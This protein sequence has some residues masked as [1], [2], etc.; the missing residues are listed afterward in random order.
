MLKVIS[1]NLGVRP[2]PRDYPDQINMEEVLEKDFPRH[3]GQQPPELGM[4]YSDLMKPEQE[5]GMSATMT[6]DPGPDQKLS[7]DEI[8]QQVSL[9]D[10]TLTMIKRQL[11]LLI[12]K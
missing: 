11:Q 2:N 6:L 8:R 12:G 10:S 4:P 9:L 5:Q 7:I 1:Q 3:K